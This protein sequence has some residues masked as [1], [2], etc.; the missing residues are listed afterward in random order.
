VEDQ[1]VVLSSMKNARVGRIIH[2]FIVKI[3]HGIK[4]IIIVATTSNIGKKSVFF[5]PHD[6]PLKS[7]PC[8]LNIKTI[9]LKRKKHLTTMSWRWP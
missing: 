1:E 6:Q 7:T 5:L 2:T 4:A 3:H 9:R 8:M